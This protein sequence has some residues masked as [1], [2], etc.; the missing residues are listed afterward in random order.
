MIASVSKQKYLA[1]LVAGSSAFFVAACGDGGVELNGKL[2]DALGVSEAAQRN[3]KSEPKLRE[4]TGLVVPPNATRL[5]EPGSGSDGEPDLNAKIADPEQRKVLA[6]AEK[7]R[8]HKAYCSGEMTWKERVG[9]RDSGSKVFT[10][11]YGPC[12]GLSEAFKQ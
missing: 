7:A 2:F 10:S 1:I 9:D 6:A 12:S 8:L 3:S 11:P 5:P 4:R